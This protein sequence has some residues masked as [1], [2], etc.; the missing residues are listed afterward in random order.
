MPVMVFS[1]VWVIHYLWVL[2]FSEA[3]SSQGQ[4]VS[5][6]MAPEAAPWARYVASQ[7]YYLSYTYALSL[8]FAA[9]QYRRYR[10]R[11]SCNTRR[12]TFG[13]IGFS[14]V[15]STGSCFLLGCCG[16]PM[17]A[18][19]LS[20]FGAGFLPFAKPIIAGVSTFLIIAAGYWIHRRETQVATAVTSQ[21]DCEC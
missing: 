20:L 16:S 8:A 9:V 12:V 2:I 10:E 18:V 6:D 14:A 1:A 21:G 4:W 13:A 7:S 3:P 15:L 5:F 11:A 19:Y 17:L